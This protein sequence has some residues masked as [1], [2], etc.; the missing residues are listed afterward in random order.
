MTKHVSHLFFASVLV[1]FSA[2][3]LTSTAA[4][5]RA[6]TILYQD[7]FSRTATLG[8]STPDIRLGD[9]GASA[10]ATWTSSGY[11]TDGTYAYYLG[12]GVRNAFLQF[13]PES[14]YV[15]TLSADMLTD[16]PD[17]AVLAYSS[18]AT[19]MYSGLFEYG[20]PFIRENADGTVRGKLLPGPTEDVITNV[21]VGWHNYAISLDT[22]ES[23]WKASFYVD[24][25]QF[26]S[27]CVYTTNPT[28]NY[29]GF[30]KFD[31]TLQVDNFTLS[32]AEVPEPGTLALLASGLIGLLCY[33]W[34]RRK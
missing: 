22:R 30:G 21:P 9:Y 12:D 28:I 19:T 31:S 14:G 6:E 26:G 33:A 15:Y 24:G 4:E 23:L 11:S 8:S 25:V 1:G 10:T 34:R 5:S 27:T 29:V 2:L 18:N 16:A 20:Q 7:S 17:W 3:I 32:V 13:Q